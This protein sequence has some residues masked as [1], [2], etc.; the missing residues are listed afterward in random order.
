MNRENR[1]QEEEAEGGHLRREA[2]EAMG[3]LGEAFGRSGKAMDKEDK[4]G[5]TV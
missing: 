1:G 2:E 5:G 3:R 4:V